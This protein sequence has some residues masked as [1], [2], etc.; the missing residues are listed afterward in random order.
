MNV[1]LSFPLL[2]FEV[3]KKRLRR[4]SFTHLSDLLPMQMNLNTTALL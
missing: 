1:D 3:H 4:T 2:A